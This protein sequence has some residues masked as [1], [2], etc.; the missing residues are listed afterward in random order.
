MKEVRELKNSL[1]FTQ[2]Q[3]SQ[4]FDYLDD[5][6]LQE[7][8]GDVQFLL[9]KADDLENCSGRNYLFFEGI[10]KQG[11]NETWDQPEP[12]IKQLISDKLE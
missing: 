6:K 11:T 2:G 5:S 10:P 1:E 3:V 12:K 8:Q 4:L 7:L 9:D